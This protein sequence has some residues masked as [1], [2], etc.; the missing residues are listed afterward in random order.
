MC[1]RDSYTLDGV[2]NSTNFASA[3]VT[4]PQA[5][6]YVPAGGVQNLGLGATLGIHTLKLRHVTTGASNFQVSFELFVQDT[7]DFTATNATN[8]LTSVGHTLTNG[9]EIILTGSDLPNGL[10][11]ATKYYVC[12]LYTS[13]SPRDLSTSRMPSSA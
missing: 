12:L 1:I 8:I 4:T 7:Q 3:S 10:S 6:R 9:D 5:G 2:N 13:P 11:A